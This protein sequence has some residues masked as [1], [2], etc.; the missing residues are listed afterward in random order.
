MVIE[1]A[2]Q[3][4]IVAGATLNGLSRGVMVSFLL[5]EGLSIDMTNEQCRM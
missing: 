1:A 5:V 3:D 4:F 2:I